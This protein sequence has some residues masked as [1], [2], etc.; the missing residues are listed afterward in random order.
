[1]KKSFRT[2]LISDRPALFIQLP[3]DVKAAFGKARPPVVVTINGHSWR[4]TVA[5]YGGKSYLPV[6]A[7]NRDA[8][9][10]TAG[11]TVH[12]TVASDEAPRI[13]PMPKEL[14]GRTAARAAWKKLS[15]SHQREHAEALAEAKKPETRARRVE[16]MIAMLLSGGSPS[17]HSRSATRERAPR[18]R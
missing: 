5:V 7:S 1:M 18:P 6:R 3:F 2:R 10:V 16:K 17:R 11:E 12:V 15:Y 4:S 8:A 9:Q 14:K 13:V